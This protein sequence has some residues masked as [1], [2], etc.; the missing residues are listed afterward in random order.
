MAFY[1]LPIMKIRHD[2]F[3]ELVQNIMHYLDLGLDCID[4]IRAW[5]MHGY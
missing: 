5:I 3:E 2:I 1:D 4:M